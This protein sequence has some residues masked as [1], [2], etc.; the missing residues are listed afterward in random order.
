MLSIYKTTEQG[1]ETIEVIANGA[2]VNVVD[3]TPDEIEKLVN[4]GWIWT[5]LIFP[6]PG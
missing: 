6:R 1:L 3:P 4:W 5:M 2:W